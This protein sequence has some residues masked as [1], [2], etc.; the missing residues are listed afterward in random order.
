LCT[1]TH[2]CIC[3]AYASFNLSSS[4]FSCCLRLAIASLFRSPLQV[5]YIITIH[6]CRN[7]KIQYT[8]RAMSAAMSL[9]CCS[10]MLSRLIIMGAITFIHATGFLR[11]VKIEEPVA[12][13]QTSS[14]F[15]HS[16]L[17]RTGAGMAGD[18]RG[19]NCSGGEVSPSV[20]IHFGDNRNPLILKQGDLLGMERKCDHG[21]DYDSTCQPNGRHDR[22]PKRYRSSI[23]P[24]QCVD[25]PI[26]NNHHF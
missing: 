12:K 2:N 17:I 25:R 24:M 13:F 20:V 7:H 15:K 9:L 10:A 16:H 18:S 22:R 5:H 3:L 26:P 4:A 1:I 23:W 14:C 8:D 19:G 21:H 6:R 11:Q